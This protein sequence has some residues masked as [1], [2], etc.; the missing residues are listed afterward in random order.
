MKILKR[1]K[2]FFR[3]DEEPIELDLLAAEIKAGRA[4]LH[5]K[6]KNAP[7][8]SVRADDIGIYLNNSSGIS[9]S[10]IT[11]IVKKSMGS[12]EDKPNQ[13]REKNRV[14]SEKREDRA[15]SVEDPYK[16]RKI[17]FSLY[18]DEYDHFMAKVKQYGYKQ[19]DFLLACVAGANKASIERA[20]KKVVKTHRQ[21]RLEKQA[22]AAQMAA[23]RQ[24]EG[25]NV[26]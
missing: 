19:T 3:R 1:I 11:T 7:S 2:A 21:I 10:D 23:E 14:T 4:F 18:P 17:S 25:V 15:Q 12:K 24:N 5:P 13:T 20:H 8:I 9:Q 26:V 22:L 6:D 16:K